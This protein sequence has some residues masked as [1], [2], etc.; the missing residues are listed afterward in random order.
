MLC[1]NWI[2][3]HY[4][5]YNKIN[6][7]FAILKCLDCYYNIQLNANILNLCYSNNITYALAIYLK[8]LFI[9]LPC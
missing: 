2:L 7:I 9:L 5:L 6:I 1:Y 3:L 8:T 4:Q